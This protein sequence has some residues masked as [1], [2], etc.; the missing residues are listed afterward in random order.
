MNRNAELFLI[1]LSLRLD[2][3]LNHRSREVNRFQDNRIL[4]I[5]NRIAGLGSLQ[6]NRSHDIARKNFL[7]FFTLVDTQ[8][9]AMQALGRS[10]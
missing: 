8:A 4:L 5:T 9:A 3:E 2:G 7:N 10:A 6:T 1:Y